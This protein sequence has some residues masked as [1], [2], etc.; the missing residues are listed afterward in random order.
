MH[1][2]SLWS[3]LFLFLLAGSCSGESVKTLI[4][5]S[6]GSRLQAESFGAFNEPWAMTFLPEGD[7]LI[8][9]KSGTLVLFHLKDRSRVLVQGV[10]EVAYGGQGGLGDIILHPQYRENHWVYLSYVERDE[11]GNSGAVVARALLKNAAARAELENLEVLWRQIPKVQ[12]TGHYSHRLAFGPEGHLFITS[13]ERQ[14]Q[15][16]AQSWTQN[17]GKVIRL[18][19]DGTVPADNP[20]QDKGELAKTFWSLGHRNLLG[21]AFD[22]EGQLWTHEMGPRHG[23]EFNLILG[24]ENYGWPLVSWGDQYSGLAIPDHDTRREFH[25]PELYWVPSIAPSGLIIYS[26]TLFSGWQGNAFIGGLVSESLIRVRMGGDQVQEVERFA[27][28]KRAQ[29][30]GMNCH[31]RD[32]NF[33]PRL[34]EFRPVGNDLGLITIKSLQTFVFKSFYIDLELSI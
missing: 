3:G 1:R 12:G 21:I 17:L 23:D 11:S 6:A 28:K 9:E 14:K 18:N 30:E 29:S 16:P 27:M 25:S 22:Q 24:G 8:S 2:F 4:E 5:G 19:P 15:T 34:P 31:R 32:S 10:P 26:G 13:G 33:L 20:F 7:L